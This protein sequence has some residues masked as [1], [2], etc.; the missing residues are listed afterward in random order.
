MSG[1]LFDVFDLAVPDLSGASSS[2]LLQFMLPSFG[3][4]ATVAEEAGRMTQ[5]VDGF[6]VC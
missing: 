2:G 4:P 3:F 5:R 6:K 1:S